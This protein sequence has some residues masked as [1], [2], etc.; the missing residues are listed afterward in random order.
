MVSTTNPNKVNKQI[1][2]YISRNI[3]GTSNYVEFGEL[4]SGTHNFTLS[5]QKEKVLSPQ[6]ILRKFPL[7]PNIAEGNSEITTSGPVGMLINGVEILNYKS[8]DKIYYGPLQSV[9]VLS[10]GKGYDVINPPELEV[11]EGNALIQP[12][13]SGSVEKVYVVPQEFNINTV[14]S[15]AL[16]G[17]NGTGASFEPVIERK[18]RELIFDAKQINE[19]GGVDVDV[20]TITFLSNHGLSNGEPI[21]YISSTVSPVGIGNFKGN[22]FDTG[23][24]LENETT[25]YAKYVNNKTMELYPTFT[26]YVSGINTIG[27]TTAG[28]AGLQKFVTRQKNVLTG[29]KVLNGGSGYSNRKLRV[30]AT[31]ISTENDVVTYTNHGFKDGELITYSYEQTQISGLSTSKQ[32]YVIK[33]DDNNFKLALS[34]LNANQGYSIDLTSI[35]SGSTH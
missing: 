21:I 6:K 16:T 13:L 8:T 29:I 2:L 19:G 15:I 33:I 5:S 32:Y 11:S 25:Y 31:G 7:N 20:D 27:F 24:T 18:R 28:T 14:V 3:V 9:N 22:N 12:I 30:S 17:G 1:R 34:K 35:G 10:G 23:E 26:D 4:T